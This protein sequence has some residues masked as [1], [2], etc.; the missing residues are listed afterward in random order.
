MNPA[1][2]RK[3]GVNANL[4]EDPIFY[5]HH[6][7]IDRAWWTWQSQDLPA[8]LKDVSG[9]TDMDDISNVGTTL[10]TTLG[11]GQLAPEVTIADV[12]DIRD[13][14]LCYEYV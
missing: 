12:M 2:F 5:M 14:F 10:A 9:R 11:V 1:T 7:A 8:R 13:G 3:Y 6:A 4:P